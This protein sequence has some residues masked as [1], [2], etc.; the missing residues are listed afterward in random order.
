MSD[1]SAASVAASAGPSL[2]RRVPLGPA[3]TMGVN[4]PEAMKKLIAAS[5]RSIS[6]QRCASSGQSPS[7]VRSGV[8]VIP[9]GALHERD[10]MFQTRTPGGGGAASRWSVDNV[11]VKAKI[12]H[13]FAGCCGLWCVL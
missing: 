13:K 7:I 4:A 3:S 11:K 9:N 2:G 8:W 6:V 1:G 12:L 10:C 5:E